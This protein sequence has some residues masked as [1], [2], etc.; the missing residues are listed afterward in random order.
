MTAKKM[1]APWSR[2]RY[3]KTTLPNGVRVV[4]ENHPNA[5]AL[6]LG[7]FMSKGTRDEAPDEAGLAHF[8]EHM[9]FKSTK[10]DRM[11]V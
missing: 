8:V 1:T 6:S 3:K 2:Y 10:N 4:T 7:F 9:V 5:V 11:I